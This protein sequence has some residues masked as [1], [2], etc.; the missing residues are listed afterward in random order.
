MN[1]IE[2]KDV[3]E[4]EYGTS[5]ALNSMTISESG[6]PFVSRQEKNNGVVARVEEIEGIDPNPPHTLSVAASGSVLATFY[7]KEP[8][9]SAFHVFCLTPKEEMNV[10]EMLVYSKT[11]NS[12]KYKYSYGRQ[13]NKTLKELLIPDRTEIKAL[14]SKFRML[15]LPSQESVSDSDLSLSTEY[16]KD[17]KYSE[18]F[19]IKGTKTTPKSKLKGYGEGRYPYVTTQTENNGVESFYDFYT[20]QGNV[21]TVDSA[22]LGYCSYQEHSFSASDHVE[23]LI[24]KF[25]MNRYRAMFL[26]TVLNQEQYRYNY[27]RKCS[28]GRMEN[29]TIRLPA[30]TEGNPDWQ[31]ME[32]YIKSLPYSSNL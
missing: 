14:C 4:V 11:I 25:E 29:S 31:L 9:Y 15:E 26:V 2:L 21:L 17:F 6:I 16:W 24:P 32:D 20:E 28:Q 19:D 18:L 13:A 1:L 8:Y 3:F 7:Q 22:T 23:K 12:N 10:M 5:L 30:N 27:G